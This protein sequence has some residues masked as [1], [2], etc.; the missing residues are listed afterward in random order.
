MKD[1]GGR[2]RSGWGEPSHKRGE[3]GLTHVKG[4]QEGRIS[5]CRA[6]WRKSPPGPER[7]SEACM[8]CRRSPT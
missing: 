5:A 8:A 3:A 1:K 2:S 6:V 4:E 7:T